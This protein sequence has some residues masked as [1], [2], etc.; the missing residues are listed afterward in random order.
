MELATDTGSPTAR[1]DAVAQVGA[2]G[3]AATQLRPSGLG[4]FGENVL[5]VVTEGDLIEKGTA[6]KITEVQGSRVVV[7]R[8]G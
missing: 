8:A 7:A 4:Q 5:D 6:I 2:T 1:S 3:I